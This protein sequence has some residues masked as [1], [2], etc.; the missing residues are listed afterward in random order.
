[1]RAYTHC[2]VHKPANKSP[3]SKPDVTEQFDHLLYRLIPS[4]TTRK[5]LLEVL[6]MT[7]C[8][9]A[10]QRQR[11][12]RYRPHNLTALINCKW[13]H[14]IGLFAC[15]RL[16]TT[17]RLWHLF[18]AIFSCVLRRLAWAV[19]KS[20]G[21]LSTLRP[22]PVIVIWPP[23]WSFNLS[24]R[25][26]RRIVER[27]IVACL[28]VATIPYRSNPTS[29]RFV[30]VTVKQGHV[31]GPYVCGP[32]TAGGARV[33][34]SPLASTTIAVLGLHGGHFSSLRPWMR[35]T[36]ENRT[37]IMEDTNISIEIWWKT[38]VLRVWDDDD[39]DEGNLSSII[40]QRWAYVT[41]RNAASWR[42]DDVT[43]TKSER[44]SGQRVTSY[45]IAQRVIWLSAN[46]CQCLFRD[47]QEAGQGI[48]KTH[49][50]DA[51]RTF[52]IAQ[53]ESISSSG[54]LPFSALRARNMQLT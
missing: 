23:T 12:S 32:I 45:L 25:Y 24:S 49:G 21:R 35:R 8:H 13:Q 52:F 34:I 7:V 17:H 41:Q 30:R 53:T 43:I 15:S 1:M 46:D 54:P 16:Y 48:D 36:D 4:W 28:S 3:F 22:G 14:S 5:R 42:A 26:V 38:I 50:G 27:R 29:S 31:C 51:R 6:S 11:Q 39:D 20:P 10:W 9:T 18:D 19:R 2:A 37:L 33:A 40:D 44:L 47:Y